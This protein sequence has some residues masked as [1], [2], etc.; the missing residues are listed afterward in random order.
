MLAALWNLHG[1]HVVAMLPQGESFNASWFI[2]QNLVPLV[3][4]FFPSGWSPSKKL[5][6]HVDNALAHNSRM[7]RNFFE[8][9][10]LKRLPHRPYSPDIPPSDFSLFGKVNEAHRTRNSRRNQPF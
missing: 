2:D 8:H 6:I 4:S 1:F 5:M 3:Q 9:G 7:T 10:P